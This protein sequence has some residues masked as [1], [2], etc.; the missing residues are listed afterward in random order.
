MYGAHWPAEYGGTGVPGNVPFDAFHGLI[1]SDELARCAAGGLIAALYCIDIGLPPL[2][3]G[4]REEVKR[5]VATQV[6]RGEE[7]IAL[8]VTEPAGGSDVARV[9]TSAKKVKGRDGEEYYVVN[10]E[11]KYITNGCRAD[12]YTTVVRTGGEGMAGISVLLIPARSKGITA[13]RMKTQ[14]LSVHLCLHLFSHFSFR[15]FL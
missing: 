2:L 5:E 8:A 3:S 11:K 13:R 9:T 7:I 15:C 1:L 14:G 4:G 12:Y 6:I 10:W